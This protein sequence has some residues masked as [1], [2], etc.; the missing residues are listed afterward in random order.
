MKIEQDRKLTRA[1]IISAVALL[2]LTSAFIA[3]VYWLRGFDPALLWISCAYMLAVL[4][5]GGWLFS[6]LKQS[7]SVV[8][9][10]IESI[11]TLAMDGRELAATYEE[12]RLSSLQHKLTRYIRLSQANGQ[13]LQQEKDRIKEL[14]SDIS[15]QTKTPLSNIMLYSQLLAE[16]PRLDLEAQELVSSIQSQS[17]KLKWLIESLIKLSRLEAGI[18]SLHLE[19]APVIRTV[20]QAVSA[21]YSMAES[22]EIQVE[23]ICDPGI[24]ALHDVKW[25]GE[26]LFNLLENAVKYTD[27]GGV[28]RVSTFS[29]EMFTRI[30]VE[31]TGIGIGEEELP[32]IFKRFYRGQNALDR[33]G[34]GIGLFLAREIVMTQGGHIK[35]FSKLGQGTKFS[36]F[37]PQI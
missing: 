33:E 37:L 14:I 32:Y 35:V 21:M 4:L 8:F 16:L 25:T 28:I 5:L 18:I 19:A 36:V 31:D 6:R 3:V 20:Q 30:D 29:N 2:I 7:M 15:H 23:V 26:A 1:V 11:V 10:S 13:T 24:Q 34:V 27:Q 22:K 9:D 17:D 12:N